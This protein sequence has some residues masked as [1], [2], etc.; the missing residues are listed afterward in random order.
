MFFFPPKGRDDDPIWRTHS[1]QG[2][3]LNHQAVYIAF[4]ASAGAASSPRLLGFAV[5]VILLILFMST[6][7]TLRALEA[8]EV[9]Q[10]DG[11]EWVPSGNLT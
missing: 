7:S 11:Y 9:G 10:L 3:R 6:I 2:G 1:F 4:H 5:L 8:L